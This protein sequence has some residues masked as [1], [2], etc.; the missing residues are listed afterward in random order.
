M[1]TRSAPPPGAFPSQPAR[2]QLTDPLARGQLAILGT[3][4]LLTVATWALTIHQA[5]TMDMSMGI[6]VRDDA[7]ATMDGMSGMS[8]TRMADSGWSLG[9][10]WAF[11]WA[12]AVMMAAMMFPAAAPTLLLFSRVY[13]Q[14]RAGSGGFV[15]TWVFAAG[16]LVVWSAIGIT[17]YVLIQLGSELAGRL[18]VADREMW[19]RLA[20]GVTIVAAGL[21]QLT[22]LKHVCLDHCRSPL[23]YVMEHWRDGHL[24]ALRMGIHH[25]VYCLGCCWAL[26]AVMVAAGV[27]S[28]G[29][30]LLLTLVVFVEK[31]F[32]FGRR[33][34][35]MTGAT[36][37]GMGIL[38]A[39]GVIEMPW[40][41]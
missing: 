34:A 36:L 8:T 2:P 18:T 30:M 5:R 24:G 9:A 39:A 27:M 4:L 13:A 37:L 32:P 6:A 41:A 31:V 38:V 28:L 20:L 11:L 12:W 10:A 26:F 25:G 15:P 29:W 19:A 40:M 35:S 22:P 23:A 1:L 16:Y 7:T 33:V 14:R 3:L 21:Y 17:V